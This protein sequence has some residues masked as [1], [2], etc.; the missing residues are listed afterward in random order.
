MRGTQDRRVREQLQVLANER[1][2]RADAAQ[3]AK[4]ALRLVK[5]IAELSEKARVLGEDITQAQAD[6]STL[7]AEVEANLAD[8]EAQI[9]PVAAS[10]SD[11]LSSLN[12]GS[13]GQL[14]VKGAGPLGF[15]A[16]LAGTPE[17]GA[18]VEVTS[19]PTGT[20]WRY[21][22]GLMVCFSAPLSATP[23]VAAGDV[24]ESASVIWNFPRPFASP[25]VVTPG[26]TNAS[27]AWATAHEAENGLARGRLRSAVSVASPVQFFLRAEGI[28][29]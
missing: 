9:P 10:V 2:N 7:I 16:G 15:W 17:S 29:A 18:L 11:I 24:F 12:G 1:G 21:R 27:A 28:P 20:A 26:Q 8:V 23:N 19:T 25:P 4:D 22:Y 5:M 14:Y 13:P 6:L 3:R